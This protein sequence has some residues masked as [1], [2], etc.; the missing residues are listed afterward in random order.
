MNGSECLNVERVI[1]HVIGKNVI[2][3]L[4]GWLGVT[5]G[6]TRPNRTPRITM[7][8]AI[9]EAIVPLNKTA[10]T[11]LKSRDGDRIWIKYKSHSGPLGIEKYTTHEITDAY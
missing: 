11:L 2:I 1:H 6:P 8:Y 3:I 5:Q 9:H 10:E 4:D 7:Q